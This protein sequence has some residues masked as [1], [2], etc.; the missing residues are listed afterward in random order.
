MIFILSNTLTMV[1]LIEVGIK[2]SNNFYRLFVVS[3][4]Y[5]GVRLSSPAIGIS[6]IEIRS[7]LNSAKVAKSYTVL[8]TGAFFFGKN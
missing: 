5:T 2:A 7:R 6:H 8:L 3:C 4:T 1:F